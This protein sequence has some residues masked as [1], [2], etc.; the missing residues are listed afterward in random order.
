MIIISYN[1]IN[2]I[3]DTND[4]NDIN[5]INDINYHHYVDINHAMIIHHPWYEGFQLVRLVTGI[6]MK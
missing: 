2:D 5:D 1:D 4:T 3:N 6:A